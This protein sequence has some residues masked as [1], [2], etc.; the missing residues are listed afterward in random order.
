MYFRLPVHAV[1]KIQG[2][3]MLACVADFNTC[4]ISDKTCVEVCDAGYIMLVLGTFPM[5]DNRAVSEDE[6]MGKA[7][8]SVLSNG[9]S[10]LERHITTYTLLNQAHVSH[11]NYFQTYSML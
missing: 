9:Q 5:G 11:G 8:S 4:F 7:P 10:V 3:I 1:K 6:V 2:Y